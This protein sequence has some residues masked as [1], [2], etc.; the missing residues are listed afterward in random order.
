MM[1]QK[2]TD[3]RPK[4]LSKSTYEFELRR[5]NI[6]YEVRTYDDMTETVVFDSCSKQ[7]IFTSESLQSLC[8]SHYE[9]EKENFQGV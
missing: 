9:V 8:E 7:D 4:L 1:L 2:L 6:V 5:V 3:R